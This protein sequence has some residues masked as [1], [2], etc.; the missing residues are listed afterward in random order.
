MQYYFQHNST[1]TKVL[2]ATTV[3]KILP[4]IVH[5]VNIN[6]VF[7]LLILNSERKHRKKLIIQYI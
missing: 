3:T 1:K 4:D 5:S 2:G 7:S 6:L